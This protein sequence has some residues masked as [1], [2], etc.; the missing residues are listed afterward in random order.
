MPVMTGASAL[1]LLDSLKVAVEGA[2]QGEMR[3]MRLLARLHELGLDV[4]VIETET[5]IISGEPVE[6]V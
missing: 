5:L 3:G 1:R 2:G 4:I 6:A